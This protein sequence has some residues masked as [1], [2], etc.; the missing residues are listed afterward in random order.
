MIDPDFS[1]RTFYGW[2]R[3]IEEVTSYRFLR[4]E[5][6]M[7][8]NIVKRTLLTEADLA[9]LR[10][11]YHYRVEKEEN[12]KLAIYHVFSPDKYEEIVSLNNF[13]L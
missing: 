2:L 10:Q 13:V 12:L 7:G 9:L 3:R 11:L 5:G 4:K 6:L 1:V 8:T